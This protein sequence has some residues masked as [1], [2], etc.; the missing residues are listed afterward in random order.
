MGALTGV[1]VYAC[2]FLIPIGIAIYVITGGLRATLMSDYVH[3]I[4]IFVCIYA[5]MFEK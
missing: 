3:T 1:N 4:V 5:F 2:N